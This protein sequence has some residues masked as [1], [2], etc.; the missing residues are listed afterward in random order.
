MA[1]WLRPLASFA[2]D[3]GSVPSTHTVAHTAHNSS[4][5]ESNTLFWPLSMYVM[6]LLTWKQNTYKIKK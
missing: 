4:Y 1:Q 6:K 3:R 2:E 5:M